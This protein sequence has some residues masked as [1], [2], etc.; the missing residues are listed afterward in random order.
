[1]AAATLLPPL[2]PMAAMAGHAVSLAGGKQYF[3]AFHHIHKPHRHANDQCRPQTGFHFLRNGQ[4]GRGRIADGQNGPRVLPGSAV[5]GG[6][7][8]GGAR[9]LCGFGHSGVCHVADGFTVQFFRP[10]FVMPASAILVSVTMKAP[11]CRAL[12]AASTAPGVK[13]RFLA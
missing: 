4:K 1:M 7:G 5:H 11:A 9:L 10:G 13:R 6:N 8:T 3:L 2:R 12:T